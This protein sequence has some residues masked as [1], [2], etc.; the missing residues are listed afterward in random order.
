MAPPAYSRPTGEVAWPGPLED[1]FVRVRS[2]LTLA[3]LTLPC[4][5][6]AAQSAPA[7][8][9]LNPIIELLEQKQPVFGVYAPANRR[10]G[11]GG[12][13]APDAPP[14]KTPM[15]L[16]QEALAYT[17]A[18]FLFDGTMEGAYDRAYPV[19]AQFAK[20]VGEAGVLQRTPSPRLTHPLV[21]KM[22][23]IAPDP[24][25]AAE[26]IGQ[27]LDLGVSAVVFVG[28]ESADEVKAGI[29][30][31]RFRSQGGTRPDAVGSAPALWG[32][33]EAEYRERADV[34]PLNPKGELLNWVI[35]ES[36]AGLARL[37]EIAAVPGIGVLTPG[38]GTLRGVFTTT[39]A[40]GQRTFD[41]AGW[42]AAIQ[43][44]LAT[45]KEFRLAC[46]YPATAIDIEKRMQEG[47]SVFIMNWGEPGF[48]AV[49]TG[50]KAAGRSQPGER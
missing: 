24:K 46:A 17:S 39:D 43:Q 20:A 8:R 38:A 49:E 5:A 25:I 29:A 48:Q 6:A 18:D 10:P 27:Q 42:E 21:V 9:R 19:F 7:P 36:K 37:R 23:E 32:M 22:H 45:C 41:E 4:G 35:V 26:H 30:A 47:F 16:A 15:Q 40:N 1:S 33:S 28:V 2:I 3:A 12:T 50:R 14:P 31:M 34:W 44:V 11:R 13:P